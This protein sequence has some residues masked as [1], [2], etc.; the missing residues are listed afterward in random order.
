MGR[1]CTLRARR[2]AGFFQARLAVVA[3]R[4]GNIEALESERGERKKR[5]GPR[6]GK[7]RRFKGGREGAQER[8]ERGT[9]VKCKTDKRGGRCNSSAVVAAAANRHLLLLLLMLHCC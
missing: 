5:E 2:V 4:A 8:K 1:C 9:E 7:G 3:E 6:A